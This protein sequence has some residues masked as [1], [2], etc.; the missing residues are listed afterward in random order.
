MRHFV[1]QALDPALDCPVLEARF[2]A[3]EPSR[4]Q[5]IIG[6]PADDDPDLR[7]VYSLDPGQLDAITA[8]FDV[9]FDAGDREVWLGPW[10]SIRETPYLVHTGFELPLMLEGRKPLAKFSDGYPSEW[11][12]ALMARFKP[13]VGQG[14]IDCRVIDD[15]WPKPRRITGDRV[16]EGHREV[17]FTLPGEEWRVEANRLLFDVCLKTGWN[18]TLERLEGRLLGYEEWQNDWWLGRG[19]LSHQRK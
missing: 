17:Y 13:F 10:Q 8:S 5:T 18:D 3:D 16:V 4:L 19:V 6:D 14:L 11:L 2:R 1:L 9:R 15:P 12:Q 7:N